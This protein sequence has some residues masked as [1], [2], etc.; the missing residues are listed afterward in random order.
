MAQSAHKKARPLA[1]RVCL[2]ACGSFNP[3]TVMHMRLLEMCRDH[4]TQEGYEVVGG[5]LSPVSDGYKKK[6]LLSSVHRIAMCEAAAS[7]SEWIKVDSWEAEQKEHTLTRPVMDR[8]Q[9]FIL[10]LFLF[11]SLSH[12]LFT[13]QGGWASGVGMW[14]RFASV[15]AYA[16]FVVR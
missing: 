8:F 4:L 9:V 5:Y 16:R 12:L 15:H 2:L 7:D 3:P 1:G 6:G 10:F 11:L 14:S 13:G